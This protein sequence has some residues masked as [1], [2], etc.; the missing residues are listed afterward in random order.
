MLKPAEHLPSISTRERRAQQLLKLIDQLT[1]R[2]MT[3]HEVANLLN[4]KSACAQKYLQQL[5][6]EDVIV[7][8]RNAET[9]SS[10][11]GKAVYRLSNNAE[12][13]RE[14]QEL[15]VQPKKNRSS[16]EKLISLQAQGS[17]LNVTVGANGQ[18]I[19]M[20]ADETHH[21]IRSHSEPVQRDPLVAALFGAASAAR[22]AEVEPHASSGGGW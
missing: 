6:D 3:T 4:C 11:S 17:I 18:R 16:R 22:A 5:R 14:F 1:M 2:S 7:L 12:K 8:D 13:I 15:I 10:S 21:A 20:L 19:Y 9:G